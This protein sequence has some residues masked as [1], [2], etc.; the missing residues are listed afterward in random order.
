MQDL[1]TYASR[2]LAFFIRYIRLRTM[3]H[4]IILLA[5]AGAVACSVTTQYGVKLLVDALSST[6]QN[7][8][9][10]WTSFS[11]L[12]ALI[13]ADNLLWRLASW[14]GS[15]A[16]VG[17]TGD[18]R[19]DLFRHVTGHAPGFFLKQSPASL[20]SRVTATSNAVFIIENMLVWN[21]L[22][23]CAAALGQSCSYG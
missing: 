21:V 19:G 17:V 10:V 3:S 22:P 14:V 23:P 4:A 13:T 5:V 12:V 1:S 15:S 6:G 20:T 9:A 16:F 11:V 8:S 2:P 18:L 7:I